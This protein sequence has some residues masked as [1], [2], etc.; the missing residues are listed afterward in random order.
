MIGGTAEGGGN[1]EARR[2]AEE[3][4]EAGARGEK[5]VVGPAGGGAATNPRLTMR[6]PALPSHTLTGRSL[7][8]RSKPSEAPQG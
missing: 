3:A 6:S 8:E 4:G 2:E 7:I 5:A 1:G